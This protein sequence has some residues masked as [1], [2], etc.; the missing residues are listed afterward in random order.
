VKLSATDQEAVADT[1]TKAEVPHE[2]AAQANSNRVPTAVAQ[3]VPIRLLLTSKISIT[4]FD[5]NSSPLTPSSKVS[6]MR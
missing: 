4:D 6:P 2:E 5:A 1:E 3:P